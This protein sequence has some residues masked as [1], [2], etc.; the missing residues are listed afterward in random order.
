[1]FNAFF[2]QTHIIYGFSSLELIFSIILYILQPVGVVKQVTKDSTAPEVMAWLKNA[3]FG[4]YIKFFA[5][6]TG[7]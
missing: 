3:R 5:N 2:L 4:N 7:N 1:M 6:Y